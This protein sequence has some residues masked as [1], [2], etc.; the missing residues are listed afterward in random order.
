MIAA[1]G[2]AS[3]P[4]CSRH[5]HKAHDGYDRACRRSSTSR[6]NHAPCRA[7][8]GPWEGPATAVPWSRFA[9]SRSRLRVRSRD[10]GFRRAWWSNQRFDRRPFF[11][12]EI[13][14]ISPLTALIA[15]AVFRRPHTRPRPQPSLHPRKSKRFERLKINP[16]AHWRLASAPEPF[17]KPLFCRR[18]RGVNVPGVRFPPSVARW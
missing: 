2:L 6:D 12:D 3:R 9:R 4:S 10:V 5:C 16:D 17:C 1:V 18:W 13:T 8:A 14:R 7:A 11:I 15:P